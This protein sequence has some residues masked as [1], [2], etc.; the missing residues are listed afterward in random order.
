MFKIFSPKKDT[1]SV[2]SEWRDKYDVK[3]YESDNLERGG[4]ITLFNYFQNSAWKMGDAA[5]FVDDNLAR[6]IGQRS[7][8]PLAANVNYGFGNLPQ[9]LAVAHYVCRQSEA[10]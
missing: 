5:L 9:V 10:W 6:K 7:P 1:G 4:L 8:F 3:V 2:P